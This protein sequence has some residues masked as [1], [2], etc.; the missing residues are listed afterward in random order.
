MLGPVVSMESQLESELDEIVEMVKKEREEA[1][2][3]FA[4]LT[5]FDDDGACQI[6]CQPMFGGFFV[7]GLF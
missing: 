7:L 2:F 4:S 6:W 3:A 1:E 5:Q